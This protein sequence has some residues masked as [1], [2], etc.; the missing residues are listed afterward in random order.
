[1]QTGQF[2]V[3]GAGY[4]TATEDRLRSVRMVQKWSERN[5]LWVWVF[6]M[7]EEVPEKAWDKV[8]QV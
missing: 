3:L 5:N 1:V 7:N 4:E 6:E 8:G 2:E